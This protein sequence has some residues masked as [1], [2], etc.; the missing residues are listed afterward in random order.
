[1]GLG[2]WDGAGGVLAG[3]EIARAGTEGTVIGFPA[4]SGVSRC[5]VGMTVPEGEDLSG[6]TEYAC[7][8]LISGGV[9]TGF[10]TLTSVDLAPML[11]ERLWGVGEIKTDGFID[12]ARDRSGVI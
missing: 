4:R 8:G 11:T 3:D 6:A 2:S 9:L 7:G 10:S 1:L 12:A 5:A